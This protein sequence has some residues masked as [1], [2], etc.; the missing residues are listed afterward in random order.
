MQTVRLGI[1][2]DSL[3]RGVVYDDE[4]QR[5]V[6]LSANGVALAQQQL[7]GFEIKNH[8]LFGCTAPKGL[9]KLVDALAQAPADDVIL[10]EFGG[11]DCDFNWPAISANP[12][13]THLPKTLLGDFQNCY[14]QM[15]QAIRDHGSQP[16]LM[17]LPPIAADRYFQWI[18]PPGINSQNI[19]TWLE[20]V[21]N[22][23]KQQQRYSLAI[24]ALAEELSCPLIDVRAA[25]LAHSN[26]QELLC[27]DGIHPNQQGHQ[28][29]SQVFL[30]FAAAHQDKILAT[31]A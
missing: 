16:L 1:W 3:L 7:E 19:L 17:T 20:D 23:Y 22:I 14:Q 12:Y 18:T 9:R 29:I 30:R 13:A 31:S 15:V 21:N 10:I 4:K 5:H 28:L 11:N 25:F 27:S 26:Y 24:S 2:G 8:A 6:T